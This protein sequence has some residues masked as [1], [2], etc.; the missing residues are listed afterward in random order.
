MILSPPSKFVVMMMYFAVVPFIRV[1]AMNTNENANLL[2]VMK[3]FPYFSLMVIL[4]KTAGIE[5]FFEDELS[6]MGIFVPINNAFLDVPTD[7]M[8]NFITQEDW[9]LHLVYFLKHHMFRRLNIG[10]NSILEMLTDDVVTLESSHNNGM[11]INGVAKFVH[12]NVTT[13]TGV[14]QAIDNVLI[15]AW[16]HYSIADFLF[17]NPNQFSSVTSA[18]NGYSGDAYTLFAPTNSVSSSSDIFANI[19]PHDIQDFLGYHV[20]PK[21]YTGTDLMETNKLENLMKQTLEVKVDLVERS[22]RINGHLIIQSNILANNGVIHIIDGLLVPSFEPT[23]TPT[24]LLISDVAETKCGCSLCQGVWNDQAGSISCGTRI[25]WLK[26]IEGYNEIDACR[27]VAVEEFTVEC[28]QCD[29]SQCSD[30]KAK[31]P[32]ALLLNEEYN[33][34]LY[35]KA[36][37]ETDG[38]FGVQCN[39]EQIS[40]IR[41]ELLCREASNDT[42]SPK[43]A[44]CDTNNRCCSSPLRR[45]TGGQCRDATVRRRRIKLGIGGVTER[46]QMLNDR[47]SN[48]KKRKLPF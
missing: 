14:I 34:C 25:Q 4:I 28:G 41:S 40:A 24:T 43:Y 30:L 42:C 10:D 1:L 33:K 13:S 12:E 45:C 26:N 2:E 35:L 7:L 23:M 37:E 5:P 38:D 20:V 11:I 27:K 15:P 8:I 48:S 36:L 18:F 44:R 19:N 22:M 3:T 9:K 29:P 46:I 31:S 17:A 47:V 21:I 6:T 39:C 16:Y 32:K